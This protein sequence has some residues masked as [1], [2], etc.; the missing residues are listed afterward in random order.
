MRKRTFKGTIQIRILH[1]GIGILMALG[2]AGPVATLECEQA[3]SAVTCTDDNGRWIP[4]T[5]TCVMPGDSSTG[6]STNPCD[7]LPKM[8]VE[9]CNECMGEDEYNP[10][11]F[12]TAVGCISTT[13][14]TAAKQIMTLMMGVA[15][16]V[17]V[18]AI[19]YSGYELAVSKG[20][21]G[22]VAAAKQRIANGVI[23]LLMIIGSTIFWDLVGVKLLE[24]P[25]FFSN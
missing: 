11:G 22:R 14:T 13:P 6:G 19:F 18:G 20:D 16:C 2:G 12:W 21:P 3:T 24:L 8:A 25:G 7:R 1:W 5:C 9:M 17:I 15:G 23:A 10:K 4:E